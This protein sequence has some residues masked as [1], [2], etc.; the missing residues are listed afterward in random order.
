MGKSYKSG[1]DPSNPRISYFQGIPMPGTKPPS[2][3][4]TSAASV[5]R[6]YRLLARRPRF[7]GLY[8]RLIRTIFRTYFLPQFRHGRCHVKVPLDMELDALLPLYPTWLPC[9]LEFGRLWSGSLG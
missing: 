9:Y 2:H 6:L 7:R 3:P 5:L 8:L 4:I 1:P